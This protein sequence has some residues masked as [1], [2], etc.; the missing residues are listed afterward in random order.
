MRVASAIDVNDAGVIVGYQNPGSG[1]P[2]A[3]IFHGDGT[4]TGLGH[5]GLGESWASAING[6]G[7]IVGRAFG[8]VNGSFLNAAFVYVNGQMLDLMDLLP[9]GSGWE[10]LFS[11][12]GINDQGQIV[13]SGIYNGE[14]RGYV[15]TPVPEP[16][17]LVILG[18]GGLALLRRRR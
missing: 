17:S 6:N 18:G 4:Y 2:E 5:L 1:A 15:I 3:A 13:G 14:I 12:D 8:E 16:G 10:L 11:A 7:V 9:A